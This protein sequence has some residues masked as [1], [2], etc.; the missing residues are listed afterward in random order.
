MLMGGGKQK[1]MFDQFG[2]KDIMAGGSSKQAKVGLNEDFFEGDGWVPYHRITTWTDDTQDEK[3]TLVALL[4]SGVSDDLD[5][6]VVGEG[7]QFELTIVV[8]NIMF[9]TDKLYLPLIRSWGKKGERN[10][11]KHML[12]VS[13][14]EM[15]IKHYKKE[16]CN[17]LKSTCL[18]NLPKTCNMKIEKSDVMILKSSESGTVV[19]S[20]DLTVR[21][22][23]SDELNSGVGLILSA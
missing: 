12:K 1:S 9:D 16:K 11:M 21:T 19:L 22:T 17:M 15:A 13:K 2:W 5:Y 7:S 3:V 23:E 18:F 20:V 4:P 14:M 8:P 6:Q 10:P